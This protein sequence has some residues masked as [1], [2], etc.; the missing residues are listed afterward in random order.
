LLFRCHLADSVLVALSG[1]QGGEHAGSHQVFRK[2]HSDFS[3]IF[4]PILKAF[5]LINK[6]FFPVANF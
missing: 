6:I 2:K 1:F 3:A 5:D 4:R